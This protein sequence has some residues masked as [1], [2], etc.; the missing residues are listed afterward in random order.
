MFLPSE[1]ND[2]WDFIVAAPWL[3]SNE[4][5]SY[6]LISG[7]LQ[8]SLTESELLQIARIVILDPED[9]VV[10]FLQTLETVEELTGK[11]KFEIKQAYLLRSMPE[12]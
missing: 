2:K 5:E 9:Q 12:S 10:K 1:S 4:L 6:K 8:T 7:K 3:N 11:F